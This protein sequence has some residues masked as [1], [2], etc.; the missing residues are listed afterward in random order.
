MGL[1]IGYKCKCQQNLVT[2]RETM[3]ILV[4]EAGESP[5]KIAKGREFVEAILATGEFDQV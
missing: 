4:D 3:Q 5:D 2:L 1:H